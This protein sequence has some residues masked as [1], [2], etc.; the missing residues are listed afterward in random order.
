MFLCGSLLLL[1]PTL[2]LLLL[3]SFS[4]HQRSQTP[5][6]RRRNASANPLCPI[7]TGAD[8][9]SQSEDRRGG[10]CE[11]RL[12][13]N[14]QEGVQFLPRNRHS[15]PLCLWQ[16]ASVPFKLVLGYQTHFCSCRVVQGPGSACLALTTPE[17][18][19]ATASEGERDT[20]WMK[21]DRRG[22]RSRNGSVSSSGS[23]E[24]GP[25]APASHINTG[26]F[27]IMIIIHIIRDCMIMTEVGRG[28]K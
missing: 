22:S 6:L 19:T 28:L 25:T 10:R 2:P 13:G 14:R 3:L 8:A 16:S 7:A 1:L 17:C 5:P 15:E 20:A 21:A 18:T 9:F 12:A 4:R 26:E 11:E 27:V 24:W 23:S